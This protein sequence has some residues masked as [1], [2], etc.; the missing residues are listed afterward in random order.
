MDLSELKNTG[1]AEFVS[2]LRKCENIKVSIAAKELRNKWKT[3]LTSAGGLQKVVPKEVKPLPAST[4][5]AAT[6]VSPPIASPPAVSVT[7]SE[8]VSAKT[9]S[10][11]P[12]ALIT[13]PQDSNV[14]SSQASL[15]SSSSSLGKVKP[16]LDDMLNSAGKPAYEA[17]P[18]PPKKVEE[19]S[20]SEIETKTTSSTIPPDPLEQLLEDNKELL[21]DNKESL[22]DNKE[23][24]ALEDGK[25]ASKSVTKNI[26]E[27]S[28]S[29]FT[30]LHLNK[31]EYD[32]R[33][34]DSNIR[35]DNI[36][37]RCIHELHTNFECMDA[38]I[39]V[40]G[41]VFKIFCINNDKATDKYL[42]EINKITFSQKITYLQHLQDLLHPDVFS[43]CEPFFN[44]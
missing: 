34:I 23:S 15:S 39:V 19:K 4:V 44:I 2:G 7:V 28:S 13:V 21:E 10:V 31:D 41:A 27:R 38:A 20:E 25:G 6:I 9:V 8:T 37:R 17:P 18:T 43:E 24:E 29:L 35:E 1:A 36:R 26:P 42:K 3:T 22:E 5:S 12:P 11:A 14:K 33:K 40:E 30:K 32:E 16:S